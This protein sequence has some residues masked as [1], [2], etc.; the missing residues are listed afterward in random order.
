MRLLISQIDTKVGDFAHN[1]SKIFATLQKGY[2]IHADLIILPELAL[3]GYPPLDLL[4]NDEF[5]VEQD[6]WLERLLKQT[7]L[8]NSAVILGVASKDKNGAVHNSAFVV[9]KGKIILTYNKMCLP[10]Y[11]VFDEKRY[12]TPGSSSICVWTIDGYT[13]AL[14]ICEDL[15][16]NTIYNRFDGVPVSLLI[17][18]N[19][20]PYWK[21][22]LT[23]RHKRVAEVAQ[24][25]DCYVVYSNLVGAQDEIVFDGGSFVC[26]K[27]GNIVAQS[28]QFEEAFTFYDLKISHKQ[29]KWVKENSNYLALNTKSVSNSKSPLEKEQTHH[30]IYSIPI[31]NSSK[32][33]SPLAN[34]YMALKSGLQGY[35]NKSSVSSAIVGLSGGID[36]SFTVCLVA[37]ALGA[38]NVLAVLMPSKFSSAGSIEDS[39]EL[40]EKLGVK[41]QVIPIEKVHSLIKMVFLE[42]TGIVIEGITDENLQSR[43][44][45]VYLLALSNQLGG[46]A[47]STGNKSEIAVGYSTLYGDSVGAFA[48]LKDVYKTEVYKLARWWNR[49]YP[50]KS[51]PQNIMEK[52]P[53]AELRDNQIDEDSLPN[54][55][56][57]DTIL[58][59]YIEHN[60]SKET[61]YKRLSQNGSEASMEVIDDVI[62]L[63]VRNEYKRGQMPIGSKVSEVAFGRDWR[64]LLSS[65]RIWKC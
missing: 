26:D 13:N 42:S 11:G 52:A 31:V 62:N 61:I 41:Y 36:S 60:S 7:V 4:F 50:Q 30:K 28:S 20:S 38:S 17:N 65:K 3:C 46:F 37:D 19:A 22:K 6:K 51:I 47:V 59:E 12:F 64:F 29:L 35:F 14:T 49:N 27:S 8:T 21:N 44:R 56:T 43:I 54:Y 25:L 33:L 2:E 18:I 16:S 48:P 23:Q 1:F 34:I 5:F 40:A 58:Q 10:N 53:S 55:K 15:W 39:V 32:V 63:V 45:G 9:H 57:L 24:K